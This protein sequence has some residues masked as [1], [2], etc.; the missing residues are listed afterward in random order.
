M[1]TKKSG[2]VIQDFKREAKK[3]TQRSTDS[4]AEKGGILGGGET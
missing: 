2:R 1:K 4:K 3:E